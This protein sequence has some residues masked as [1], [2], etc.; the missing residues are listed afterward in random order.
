MLAGSLLRRAEREGGFGAVMARGDADSGSLLVL[1]CERGVRKKI[2]ERILQPNERYEWRDSALEDVQNDEKANK[3]LARRR[4]FDPDLWILELDIASA[5]R[6]AAE[7][8][9]AG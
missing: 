5:E 3:F 7:M 8:T 6:F 1:L 9:E 2:V 4:R